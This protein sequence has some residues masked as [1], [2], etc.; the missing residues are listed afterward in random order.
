[1][2]RTRPPL[3]L[4]AVR[5]R[6]ASA[7]GPHYWR[8]LEELSE[9]EEFRDFLAHEFPEN[10]D[11]W[12]GSGVDRRRFLQLMSASLA[13]A[14]LAACTRQPEEK[15]VPYIEQPEGLVPGKP[16]FFATAL[17]WRGHAAPV[18]VE[19]HM[20]RP[21]KIEGNPQHPAFPGGGTDVFM[22]ASILNLYDPDRAQVVR[23]EG[24]IAS[25]ESFVSAVGPELDA[26]R[27]SGGGGLRLLTPPVTSP[28]LS[29][30][31]K[32]LLE[33]FPGSVWHRWEPV[34]RDFARAASLAAFGQPLAHRY[35]FDRARVI[36]SLD[37][38]FLCGEP[39]SVRYAA[40][41]AAGRRIRRARMELTRMYAAECSP[42]LAGAA[43]EHR[44]AL[45]PSR[46][47]AFAR[48]VADAAGVS[49]TGGAAGASGLPAAAAKLAAAAGKDL[50]AHRGAGLVVAGEGQAPEVHLLA[51]AINHALGNA[52]S[53]IEYTDAI[54]ADPVASL[55]SLKS[56]IDAMN[57]GQVRILAILGGNPVYDAP[58]DWDF[59]GA[60]RKVKTA[61]RLGFWEDETAEWCHWN[62]PMTHPL[63]T[64]SDLRAFDGT[65]TIAQ[66]LIA[67]LYQG[68]SEHE[69]VAALSGAPD[70][71]SHDI[72]KEFWSAR[73][74]GADFEGFWRQSIR[75]GF[76][77]GTALPPRS[78]KPAAA[79]LAAAPSAAA[80][81]GLEIVFRPDPTIWDGEWANNA[82]LQECPKP[83]TRITWDNAALLSP[84][85]AARLGI[86][87][88]DSVT[89]AL[90]GRS[91]KAPVLV[92]PGHP[93]DTVT[94]HLGYGRRRSGNVARGT[95]FDAYGLR[96]TA[97]LASA[98]GLAV[99]KSGGRWP[100]ASVQLHQ[101]MD[102]RNLVRA[103][104]LEKFRA[105]PEFAGRL[106]EDPATGESLYPPF[107]TELPGKEPAWGMAIDL[108]TCIG[109]A[110]CVVA[111]QAENNSPV[112][113]KEQV[114]R[115][116]EMHW[117]RI[118]RYYQGG[119]ENPK[120]YF[121][122][123][124]C[125]HCE[126][127]PCEVVCPV[128]ATVHSPEGL[129]EMIY[130]RCVGTRYCSNNCPYKVR[131]FNFLQFSDAK[132][133]SLKLLRNPNVTVRSRGVME[134]C[135]Y[136]VQRIAVARIEAEK[137]EQ[138]IRDG[139]VRTACQQACPAGAIVFGNIH[140]PSAQVSAM[141]AE[142]LNYGLLTELNTRPRTTY[143]AK[144]WNPNP[145]I[146]GEA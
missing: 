65:I 143:L 96:T 30:Q 60:L 94:A 8:G 134:K 53:T 95:G 77:A 4:D 71:T 127:A 93:D 80:A 116:R 125:M 87:N 15:I 83:L 57:A 145:E 46:L 37:S 52:G 9:T 19:S 102:G 141:K 22:Q 54:E 25:W 20:G 128:G 91:V 118:D 79:S 129:N 103:A 73:H 10:A 89:L 43:A 122:P 63:E 69:F 39:G 42:T 113:G 135:S 48:A 58:A 36:V 45:A 49:G 120:T 119:L 1:M 84:A 56:L 111:C 5:A 142:P 106:G 138:P 3:D 47:P 18:V 144:V 108:N 101:T 114:M 109:C 32:S 75:D 139:D 55:E 59:L 51:H 136:C 131:R 24:T 137:R 50:A 78:V 14:G 86:E 82:W 28:T 100:L 2:S 110:A 6:L 121:E 44:I 76:V 7:S 126:K 26:L 27:A 98:A 16:L 70:R 29:A 68:K 35:R 12:G 104:D 34:S 85:T 41:F 66:P 17:P 64:W 33:Q 40:D 133:P 107:P 97:G 115:G 112:V 92:V 81:G 72:V 130:N 105:D 132:T 99:T 67:P 61:V 13:L 38:D 124:L 117:L 90:G 11:Q 88:E 62:V 23:H 21:T 146:G 140:D 123:V 74:A 31:I